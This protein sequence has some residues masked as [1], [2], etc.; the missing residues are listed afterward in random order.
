MEHNTTTA[1]SAPHWDFRHHITATNEDAP[2][3]IGII[4]IRGNATAPAH[5]P[6]PL[7]SLRS[8][9]YRNNPAL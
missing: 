7:G 6:Y 8:V 1:A 9:N 2:T 3:P 4:V 5:T